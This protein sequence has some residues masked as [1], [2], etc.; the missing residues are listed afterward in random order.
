MQVTDDENNFDSRNISGS[1]DKRLVADGLR[2]LGKK[3]KGG[4][5]GSNGGTDVKYG[6]KTF[7]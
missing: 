5:A 3:E 7:V 2:R 1:R 4:G 6:T